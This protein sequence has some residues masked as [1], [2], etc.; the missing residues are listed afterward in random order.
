M[1]QNDLKKAAALVALEYVEEGSIVGVGT[2][3]TVNHFIAGLEGIRDR[4]AGAVSSSEAS[5]ARLA[6]LGIPVIDLNDVTD[7]PIYVDGADEIDG[8][9]N[10]IKGGGGALTREK[11]VA[12]VAT[13]FI[14]ICDA[15]KQ[16]NLLG[17]FPLPV[18]VLP[19][20]R[21]LVERKLQQ[22]GGHPVLREHF[23]TDNGNLILD[24]HGLRIAAPTELESAI[25]QI[26]GVVT[27]GLFAR[28]GADLLLLATAN[29]VERHV[30]RHSA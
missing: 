5:S 10:M 16:V 7:L 22:L 6:A 28:R 26:P 13:R 15:S 11:I 14:C 23:I 18:E 24:V 30:A 19:M 17:H 29:G 27:N 4:V 12:E 21:A 3:S 1:N 2:G 25:N 9:F 8:D 20:A